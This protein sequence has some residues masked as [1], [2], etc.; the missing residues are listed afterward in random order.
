MDELKRVTK[1][2]MAEIVLGNKV[3]G[4]DL[5]VHDKHG[6]VINPGETSTIQLYNLHKN[7]AERISRVSKV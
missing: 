2:V 5:V 3:L 4:L 6:T 7:T 1:E